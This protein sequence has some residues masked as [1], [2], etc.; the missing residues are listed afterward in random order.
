M[1]RSLC[2]SAILGLM[3]VPH[4]AS[5]RDSQPIRDATS[6]NSAGP[7]AA[8]FDMQRCVN[9]GNSFERDPDAQWGAPL[10]V[11]KFA[12]IKAAG[13]DTVRIPTRWSAY[14]GPAPEYSIDPAFMAEI[15]AAVDTALAHD[16]NVILNV[17][18]F[19]EIMTDPKNEMRHLLAIWRQ[20]GTAFSDRSD[21]LWFEALNEPNN[22]LKGKLMQAAQQVAV[23]AI[24]EENPDRIIILGGEEW[25]GINSLPSNIAPPDNNIVYTLHYYDPFGFT[26]QFAPWVPQ[27]LVNKKRNWG[28]RQ[29]K[30]D[31]SQAITVVESFRDV[32]KH[33]VFIGEFGVYDPVDNDER[34]EWV[35]AVRQA[36]ETSDIPWCLWAFSNTFA[37]YDNDKGWDKDMVGALG[38]KV[39]T[40]VNQSAAQ[41]ER[42]GTGVLGRDT[43][44]R[45]EADWGTFLKYFEGASWGTQ[46]VLSGVAEIKPGWEIH[47]PHDHPEEEY[48]MVTQGSGLWTVNGKTFQAKEGDMLYAA[49][50]DVHG[51]KNTGDS[52]L[53]F[54]FWK[55]SSSGVTPPAAPS[56]K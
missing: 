37:L 43:V 36:A 25:S 15:T 32:I 22:K 34:V 46:N 23:L 11:S 53:K 13:F 42:F 14:T 30:K 50:W 38:L 5:A 41:I 27:E 3:M 16:L 2:V 35:G 10:D 56:G 20:I 49:P 51:I 8:A 12:E 4:L 1:L 48:L 45:E 6:P 29:D 26:H 40:Q 44:E 17:H 28:S 47:P 19:E 52:V 39:P 24:R 18:H 31:L 33:P 55:W 21:N 9:M 7:I 54:V